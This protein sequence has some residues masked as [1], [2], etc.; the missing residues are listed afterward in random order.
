MENINVHMS[1]WTE[2]V[3]RDL[4]VL[5][6]ITETHSAYILNY[7]APGLRKRD[8]NVVIN[9]GM[10]FIEG[11]RINWL[12][13]LFSRKHSVEQTYIDEFFDLPVDIDEDRI[14]ATLF[15]HELKIVIKKLLALQNYRTVAIEDIEEEAVKENLFTRMMN[16][17]KKS[18]F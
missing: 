8:L 6:R 7:Q 18:F 13:S 1:P 2:E 15:D 14:T 3:N 16:R 12:T 11:R 4:S 5:A 10:I 17:L 9:E